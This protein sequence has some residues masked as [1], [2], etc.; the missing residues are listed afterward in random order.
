MCVFNLLVIVYLMLVVYSSCIYIREFHFYFVEYYWGTM[1][2]ALVYVHL[3]MFFLNVELLDVVFLFMLIY[4]LMFL[5]HV[6]LK[7]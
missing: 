5:F 4:L 7:Y 3:F 1:F 6:S 2:S